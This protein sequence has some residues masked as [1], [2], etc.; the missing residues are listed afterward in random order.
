[1]P[2]DR[3]KSTPTQ[4]YEYVSAYNICRNNCYNKHFYACALEQYIGNY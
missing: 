1:M 4:P 2:Q 3:E